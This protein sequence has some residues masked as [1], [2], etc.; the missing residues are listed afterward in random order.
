MSSSRDAVLKKFSVLLK[1]AGSTRR[2]D[3]KGIRARLN[4]R[5][6]PETVFDLQL[7]KLITGEAKNAFCER[8]LAE[9]VSQKI[10]ELKA[11][12]DDKTWETYVQ[13]AKAHR[14]ESD[15]R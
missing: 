1:P 6:A 7:I 14:K 3:F 15:R 2:V 12:H 9:A 10:K 13:C 4:L 11:R 8:V 5:M